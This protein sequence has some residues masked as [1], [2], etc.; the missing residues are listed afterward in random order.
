LALLAFIAGAFVIDLWRHSEEAGGFK[1][2]AHFR[3]PV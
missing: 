1:D 3:K 2:E